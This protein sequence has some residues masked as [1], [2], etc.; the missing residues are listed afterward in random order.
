M[1]NG[2]HIS[3]EDLATAGIELLQAAPR[4]KAYH[5]G[6]L[7]VRDRAFEAALRAANID[8]MF[9]LITVYLTIR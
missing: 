4:S 6:L 5:L 3:Q 1:T 2:E 7:G 8:V 9:E